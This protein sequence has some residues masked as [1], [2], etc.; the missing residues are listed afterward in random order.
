MKLSGINAYV[1]ERVVVE[2]ENGRIRVY[3][4]KS[5]KEIVSV[6]VEGVRRHD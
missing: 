4:A 3:D 6:S 1:G 2:F 5:G